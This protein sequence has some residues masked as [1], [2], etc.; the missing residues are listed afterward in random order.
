MQSNVKAVTKELYK[1]N[2]V[3]ITVAEPELHQSDC[4]SRLGSNKDMCTF[5]GAYR[6]NHNDLSNKTSCSRN[7][8][9]RRHR[10]NWNWVNRISDQT[11]WFQTTRLVIADA[12][13]C[14]FF[15]SSRFKHRDSGHETTCKVFLGHLE[16][17]S[18]LNQLHNPYQLPR[19]RYSIL[20]SGDF[21]LT[22]FWTCVQ[23]LEDCERTRGI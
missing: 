12:Y 5:H 7:L 17:A 8:T 20:K 3:I 15:D 22:G 16:H 23:S 2:G 6:T 10:E 21:Q 13:I 1:R 11:G 14:P 18:K 19:R 4:S 9:H